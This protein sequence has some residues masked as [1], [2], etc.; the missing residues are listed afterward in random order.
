MWCSLKIGT[1]SHLSSFPLVCLLPDLADTQFACGIM[2]S[3]SSTS[4]WDLMIEGHIS[5][6]RY[7]KS[8]VIFIL[9]IHSA[10]L[11]KLG[12]ELIIN[13][14]W[15]LW[16]IWGNQVVTLSPQP[17]FASQNWFSGLEL[18]FVH[19]IPKSHGFPGRFIPIWIGLW[20]LLGQ[21]KPFGSA[22]ANLYTELGHVFLWGNAWE[23]KN[24]SFYSEVKNKGLPATWRFFF[25]MHTSLAL[26]LCL[27]L[28]HNT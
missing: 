22:S 16:V 11:S 10:S 19:S 27:I 13:Y 6:F 5:I 25:V 3:I 21:V 24:L 20:F 12:P 26:S 23:K 9:R 14:F 8:M 1:V 28:K 4:F 17:E 7:S 2:M 18:V 15:N